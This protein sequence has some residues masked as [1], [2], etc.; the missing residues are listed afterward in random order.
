VFNDDEEDSLSFG[1]RR[2]RERWINSTNGGAD[3]GPSREKIALR[4]KTQEFDVSGSDAYIRIM[5]VEL[6][7]KR[8]R[9]RAQLSL[10]SRPCVL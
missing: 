3:R 7:K 5:N 1:R 10:A 4:K 2:R 8:R 6:E 9:L